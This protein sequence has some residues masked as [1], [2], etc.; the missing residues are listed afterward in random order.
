LIL[1]I[2]SDSVNVRHHVNYS[3]LATPISQA[4]SILQRDVRLGMQW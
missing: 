3:Y 4:D 1:K 2:I